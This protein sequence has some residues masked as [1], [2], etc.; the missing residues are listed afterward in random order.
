MSEPLY[1]NVGDVYE[2]PVGDYFE[3]AADDYRL[4]Y[5]PLADCM[6]I[7]SGADVP[8]LDRALYDR[9]KH[10]KRD[11]P[12]AD[13]VEALLDY[14]TRPE[15]VCVAQSPDRYEK[16]SLIPT[17]KC[18]FNCS[19]CYSAQG[20]QNKTIEPEK[21]KSAIDYFINP[22]RTDAG[23]LKF[24]VSGG[25]EPLLS[26]ET[27][28]EGLSYAYARA[29]GFGITLETQLITNGSVIT[30][31]MLAFFSK[32]GI[33]VCVSFEILESVQ[34]KHRRNYSLVYSNIG[35][36]VEAG[37]R[38]S[39]SATITRESVY[40]QSE[41][42]RHAMTEFPQLAGVNFDP[43]IAPGLFDSPEDLDS[44]LQDFIRYFMEARRQNENG[45]VIPYCSMCRLIESIAVRY[46]PGKLCVTPE[47]TVSVCHSVTSPK[48]EGYDQYIYGRV[49]GDGRLV[50][51][52]DK[53][54][55]LMG[56]NV[57]ARSECNECFAKWHCAG[58]CVMVNNRYRGEMGKAMCRFT[59]EFI[60]QLLMERLEAEYMESENVSL[61]E[62]VLAKA[63]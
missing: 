29:A 42:F 1:L 14:A 59:R 50:F 40:L 33:R 3:Q 12:F 43:V 27:L 36:L 23:K 16:M 39:L 56:E 4:I 2:I 44:Y 38:P 54:R 32:Y 57:H 47:S 37:L 52:M 34:N 31:E 20:R 55:R 25:G 10:G 5:S 46:C 22:K 62:I 24:F 26:W 19:Y 58:G 30:D 6:F 60:K 49:E 51:D 11:V 8:M 35:R 63:G 61:R 13:E 7:M 15:E 21:L 48:D 17:Y 45:R 53:F 9:V 28:R 18:N 41:M